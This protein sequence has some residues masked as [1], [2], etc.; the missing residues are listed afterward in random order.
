MFVKLLL[1]VCLLSLNQD[2]HWREGTTLVMLAKLLLWV[3]LLSLNQD[4]HWREG[5]TLVML[6]KLL[7]WVCLLSLNQDIHKGRYNIGNVC[8]TAS[9]S[10]LTLVYLD[11]KRVSILIEAVLPTLP[12]LY[13]PFNVYL[14]SKRVSILTEAVLQTLPM[15]YLPLCISWFKESK[16]T[17]RSSFANITN[18][19]PSLQCIY[20]DSKRVSILIEAVMP[21]LPKLCLTFNSKSRKTFEFNCQHL[22]CVY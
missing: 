2:I 9:V 6:A 11:S 7:L 20:P 22:M 15:L 19:V 1:W 5:T 12:M 16:H 18:V 3:C 14:D 17:H 10:M 8:K 21:T 4:I 13:L